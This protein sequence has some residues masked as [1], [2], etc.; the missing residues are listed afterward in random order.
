MPAPGV[1]PLTERDHIATTKP[2]GH[3]AQQL[4]T[5]F[6]NVVNQ[7]DGRTGPPNGLWTIRCCIS[8]RD[9]VRCFSRGA[10]PARAARVT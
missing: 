1:D 4:N 3:T 8:T 2:Y 7:D 5:F 6:F 10:C 9:N